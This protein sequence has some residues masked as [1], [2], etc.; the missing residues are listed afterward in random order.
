VV[1]FRSYPFLGSSFNNPDHFKLQRVSAYGVS[2]RLRIY[3]LP[4]STRGPR[5]T[6]EHLPQELRLRTHLKHRFIHHLRPTPDCRSETFVFSKS[7]LG[8]PP[9]RVIHHLSVGLESDKTMNRVAK[10]PWKYVV[11]ANWKDYIH[12]TLLAITSH[13]RVR[14]NVIAYSTRC[15]RWRMSQSVL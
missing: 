7:A 6:T 14:Q 5:P 2:L 9:I 15:Q 3:S 10:S 1:K 8:P 11:G 13:S 12:W 4:A